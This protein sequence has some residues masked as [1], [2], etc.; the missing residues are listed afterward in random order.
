MDIIA[1]EFL[2]MY[3]YSSVPVNTADK[4]IVTVS[5]AMNI[6]DYGQ[7]A[8]DH[9]SLLVL[10]KHTGQALSQQKFRKVS[11]RIKKLCTVSIP[12]QKRNAW[13]RYKQ[14]YPKENN[15]WGDFQAHRK[16]L[17]LISIGECSSVE[18]F[19]DLFDNYKSVK[20]EYA[21]TL[22]NSRLIVFGMNRDGTPLEEEREDSVTSDHSSQER[23]DSEDSGV[24]SDISPS[25]IVV[26]NKKTQLKETK[27]DPYG[28]HSKNREGEI[29]FIKKPLRKQESSPLY[30]HSP[31]STPP[32]T[33]PLR[34]PHSNSLTKDSTGAEVVFFPNILDCHDLEEKLKEFVVSLFFVL[35]GKR[36]DRS[37]ERH[38]RIQLLCAPFERKDYIG[39]DT[40]TKYAFY[41]RIIFKRKENFKN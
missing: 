36:L 1:I 26:E 25:E 23:A 6:I 37:F 5:G 27:S 32:G 41:I 4:S 24:T 13:V 17:G 29:T 12:G 33:P 7:T 20:E 21:S 38:D 15:D 2:Y 3:L 34:R 9:Q 22:F 35:E 11:D 10:V 40:D 31:L 14:H 18:E 39:L 19:E 30:Q 28:S 16:V 8:E